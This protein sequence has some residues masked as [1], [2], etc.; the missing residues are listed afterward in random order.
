MAHSAEG[1]NADV[2]LDTASQPTPRPSAAAS[3]AGRVRFTYIGSRVLIAAALL[4]ILVVDSLLSR[5]YDIS[6]LYA[7]VVLGAAFTRSR[8]T[9]LGTAIA[10]VAIALGLMLFKAIGEPP[11][12]GPI[13]FAHSTA[14]ILIVVSAGAGLLALNRTV[15]AHK[16]SD[17]LRQA[18]QARERDTRMLEAASQV[19]PIGTWYF[20]PEDQTLTW[21]RGAA[22]IVEYE[23]DVP[24]GMDVALGIIAPEDRTRMLG[25]VMH[26]IQTET[27]FREEFTFTSGSGAIKR[28]VIMGDPVT[29]EENGRRLIHGSVQDI[30]RWAAAEE[31]A[32]TAARRFRAMAAAVPFAV[33]SSGADGEIDYA[34]EALETFTGAPPEQA[35]DGGWIDLI[36]PDDRE[37]VLAAWQESIETG[38]PYDVEHRLRAADGHFE[39]FHISAQ[40]EYDIEGNI[41][42]W[43]GA[44]INVDATRK[45]RERAEALAA[46]RA[47]I[48]ESTTDSIYAVD[49]DWRLVYANSAARSLVGKLSQDL[50][51][52]LLWDVFPFEP[53][54][55]AREG[56]TL[57]MATGNPQ[58]F[59]YFSKGF[60]RWFA[61]MATPTPR[62][63]SVFNRDVSETKRLTE[64]LVQ[65]QRL[66]SLGRLTGGIA[67]DFN[68]VLTVVLGG[69]E[70]VA[71]DPSVGREAREMAELVVES[72][73]RGADLT[74]R[75]LA[76]SRRQA[77]EP[78]AVDLELRLGDLEPMLHRALGE[79][80]ELH[81]APDP[82]LPAVMVD[83]VQ[84]ENA[85]LNLVIN[86]RDAMPDGG[87]LSIGAEETELDAAYARAHTDVHPGR[88]VAITVSDTGTGVDPDI[89]ERLFEPFFTTK[90]SG[91]G[92]GLGLAMVWGFA[93]QT[94]GHV[95]VYS[96]P[97][98]GS[99]FRLYLP[100]SSVDAEARRP[101]ELPP[102][103]PI[104]PGV[105]LLAED[106][107][108]VRTFATER[109]RSL[110][111]TVH[112]A[113]S[114]PEALALLETLGPIDL[115]FTDVVMPGGMSGRDL[116]D[117]VLERRP[118]TPV[119]FTSGYT[120]DVVLHNGGADPEVT[121]LSK[122]YTAEQLTEQITEA[123]DRA[124]VG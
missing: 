33:W 47:T 42:R 1:K 12:T 49:H 112:A 72:A 82:G 95:S 115:L 96:E 30:T 38:R 73:K 11:D 109:L 2:G 5:G 70:A 20:D 102:L 93:K 21:R 7:V 35:M 120:E 74:S 108:L 48:L 107:D 65:A 67:H 97:G 46:E 28:I 78:Q 32:Q 114:G 10:G 124:E 92:S 75:M 59:T 76:F 34:N 53:D 22:E 98:V 58:S 8:I 50:V 86:A 63:L 9:V 61:V 113:P 37:S 6:A 83:P 118:G 36:H 84:L 55:E 27:P 41:T 90:A 13:V 111:H 99:T 43:W 121:L 24:Y 87:R 17:A 31:E 3:T 103:R 23:A 64:Q 94:G 57:A 62:G 122:P 79:T 80:I 88:Y 104:Q 44:S 52:E 81:V 60:G 69:A 25:T 14:I 116:A 66:D 91:K 110:G 19:A 56:L 85:L 100:L 51:G 4:T 106:D 40:P 26:A 71:H 117:A 101:G 39:Y 68:N 16:L 123:L 77:L 15:Q 18:E 119:L 29:S 54:D 45:L 105:I 89:V